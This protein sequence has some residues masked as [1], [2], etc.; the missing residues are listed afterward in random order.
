MKHPRPT[1]DNYPGTLVKTI[2]FYLDEVNW[3]G[4]LSDEYINVYIRITKRMIN[5]RIVRSFDIASVE[6][7][8]GHQ[9]QAYF[10]RFLNALEHSLYTHNESNT[11]DIVYVESILQDFLVGFL[12]RRGFTTRSSDYPPSM[13]KFLEYRN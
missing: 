11:F 9:H 5:S 12:T 7:R 1:I 2:N 10:T 13:F 8:S 6:V 4:W 3:R